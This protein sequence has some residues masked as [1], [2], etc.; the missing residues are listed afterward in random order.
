MQAQQVITVSGGAEPHYWVTGSLGFAAEGRGAR[1]T[2]ADFPE[3][4]GEPY[5]AFEANMFPGAHV[6]TLG[7]ATYLIT[8]GGSV[9]RREGVAWARTRGAIPPD[10]GGGPAQVDRVLLAPD[11]R[12]LIHAHSQALHFADAAGLEGGSLSSE[13]MPKY[14]WSLGFVR[15]RVTGTS[16]E[17]Q[18]RAIFEREA[19]QQWSVAGVLPADAS[20]VLGVIPFGELGLAAVTYH[21]L[22]IVDRTGLRAPTRFMR[23]DELAD[24]S[25]IAP[26]APVV[27]VAAPRPGLTVATDAPGD[28][29]SAPSGPNEAAPR[30]VATDGPPSRT[31]PRGLVA[32]ESPPLKS[33]RERLG[34]PPIDGVFLFS[35]GRAAISVKATDD[36]DPGVIVLDGARATFL[37]CDLLAVRNIVGVVEAG[38]RWLAI[39]REGGV[40]VLSADRRCT[41]PQAPMIVRDP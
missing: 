20:E 19:P 24:L 1:L 15:G 39:S 37:R 36:S 11:G 13:T 28:Q 21:G 25:R 32:P 22:H 27:P 6:V 26:A 29:V 5:W 41:E 17:G 23:A 38:D 14:I 4:P 16:Y 35:S 9:Y 34:G 7:G 12:A 30:T 8:H 40:T 31:A 2:R 33:E 3:T 10:S 18:R